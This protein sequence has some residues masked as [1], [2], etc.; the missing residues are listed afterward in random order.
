MAYYD[1]TGGLS[2]G[3]SNSV[4]FDVI[5]PSE[6]LRVTLVWTD[7]PSTVAAAINLVNNL[8]LKLVGPDST[9]YYPNGLDAPD[10]LNN[11]E[12]ID[13]AYPPAGT[14]TVEISGTEVVEGPQPYALV[15]SGAIG[16]VPDEYSIHL[17]LVLRNSP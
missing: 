3:E 10:T 9:V 5:S 1:V 8:D 15:V 17:P 4:R 13:V 14:Y 7:Y 6:P 11:V 16:V 12:G 2:T